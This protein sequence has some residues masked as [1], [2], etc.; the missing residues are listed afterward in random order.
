MCPVLSTEERSAVSAWNPLL[1]VK[2]PSPLCHGV[3]VSNLKNML[4]QDTADRRSFASVRIPLVHLLIQVL[5][6]FSGKGRN[7]S[8]EIL[9]H[10][11]CADL[12]FWIIAALGILL[13]CQ[14]LSAQ[15]SWTVQW[16]GTKGPCQR[17]RQKKC[18]Q[19][20]VSK[21]VKLKLWYMR[22]IYSWKTSYLA[23]S[24]CR[25]S[26]SEKH[27]TETRTALPKL[28]DWGTKC[29]TVRQ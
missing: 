10:H 15:W 27:T 16:D 23:V 8:L 2:I 20:S 9:L 18:L 4:D 22:M 25:A 14:Y 28:D 11:T 12:V 29:K 26:R 7:S 6:F 19:R 13:M 21:I 17:V 5:F 3:Y 24:L 1:R